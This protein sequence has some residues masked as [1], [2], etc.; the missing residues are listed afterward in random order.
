MDGLV[1]WGAASI[2]G[3]L[4]DGESGALNDPTGVSRFQVSEKLVAILEAADRMDVAGVMLTVELAGELV[5]S[6]GA[7]VEELADQ[8][9]AVGSD[10]LV[11][12]AKAPDPHV[13]SPFRGFVQSLVH[14]HVP[15]KNDA[16]ISA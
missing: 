11:E 9:V 14:G 1:T 16:A 10:G 12:A 5:V 8:R 7:D 4:P 2:S 3:G 15:K 13:P 6:G